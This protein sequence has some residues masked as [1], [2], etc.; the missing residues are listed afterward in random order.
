MLEVARVALGLV[1]QLLQ[2]LPHL[3]LDLHAQ[4][5]RRDE[6]GLEVRA[7]L[8]VERRLALL[9]PLLQRAQLGLGGLLHRVARGEPGHRAVQLLGALDD[10]VA[11][12]LQPVVLQA[13]LHQR[14]AELRRHLAAAAEGVQRRLR[15][16]SLDRR[17]GEPLARLLQRRVV[18]VLGV[19]AKAG[20][21][22]P[23]GQ[24][25]A[26]RL[27]LRHLR[28]QRLGGFLQHLQPLR[29]TVDLLGARG[30]DEG[31]R[32]RV[33]ELVQVL[34]LRVLH[35]DAHHVGVGDGAHVERAA[36][37]LDELA[38]GLLGA[39]QPDAALL[40]VGD[41]PLQHVL[42]GDGVRQVVDVFAVLRVR[43]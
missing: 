7:G 9:Q 35:A 11:Q 40:E 14:A 22:Q 15:L 36:Q 18:G 30:L 1:L 13:H 41:R 24:L 29:R 20:Q 8:A 19:L 26:L 3:L 4:V 12:R 32:H 28:L 39:A 25:G 42:A 2:R 23:L 27:E 34:A 10:L 37:L 33:D 21:P 6:P 43:L 16:Q 31:P 38:L 5:Q 17:G